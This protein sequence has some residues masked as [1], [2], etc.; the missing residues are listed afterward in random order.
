MQHWIQS[1]TH[2]HTLCNHPRVLTKEELV[3]S[4]DHGL[5]L[6]RDKRTETKHRWRMTEKKH[7]LEC[8]CMYVIHTYIHGCRYIFILFTGHPII[9]D[10][11][12]LHVTRPTWFSWF[13]AWGPETDRHALLISVITSLACTCRCSVH[14][15]DDHFVLYDARSILTRKLHHLTVQPQL[16]CMYK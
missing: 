4:G 14:H 7:M 10:G 9:T 12:L 8:L 15:H 5:D 11:L 6:C 13:L 16:T 2:I 3:I 1:N